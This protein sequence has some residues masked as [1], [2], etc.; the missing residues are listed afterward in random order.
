M[1]R[2]A[3]GVEGHRP[4]RVSVYAERGR[5]WCKWTVKGR[6]KFKSWPD[7]KPNRRKALA[8][9]R[10]YAAERR[11]LEKQADAVPPAPLTLASLWERYQKANAAD[12]RAKTAKDYGQY[13]DVL[14]DVLGGS[15]LVGAI[16]LE[17]VDGFKLARR[18]A[19]TAHSQVRRQIGF[20]RQLM[21]WAEGR[22]LI[23]R[24]RLRAYRY[25][26][27]KDERAEP[28]G[29]YSRADL[30]VIAAQLEAPR[31]WRARGVITLC[32]TL[33]AR[34]NAVLHL[35]WP[36]VDL[37]AGTVAWRSEWDKLGEERVQPL[38]PRAK[39]ALVEA[40][41]QRHESEPWV[42]WAVRAKGRPYHYNSVVHHLW[43]AE[44]RAGVEHLA[45]RAF[46]GLRRMVVGDVGDLRDAGAWVGQKSLKVTAGYDRPRQEQVERARARIAGL[47]GA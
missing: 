18:K 46:H 41:G 26:I 38:T 20:L 43:E 14:D 31:H 17:D 19:G 44:K 39:A 29:E 15:S 42:F 22:E 45:G 7:S 8:W 33:G 36:D 6:P 9:A 32:G 5:V 21:N 37:D 25:V 2:E 12:W 24:N 30:V 23:Q 10:Q 3:L 47:E 16:T 1:S 4:L 13:F 28:P 34:I 35:R 40:W 11:A 27:P